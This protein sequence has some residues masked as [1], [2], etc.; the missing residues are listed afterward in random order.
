MMTAAHADHLADAV[1]LGHRR[2]PTAVT[3]VAACGPTGPVTLAIDAFSSVSLDPPSVMF[4]VARG[5]HDLCVAAYRRPYLFQHIAVQPH[6][7]AN[8]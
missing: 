7:R 6:N 2:F 5:L 1:K 3:V 4:Y 8:S